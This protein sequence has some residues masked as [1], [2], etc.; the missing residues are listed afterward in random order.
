M[1]LIN[2]YPT[3][4][5]EFMSMRPII[6]NSERKQRQKLFKKTDNEKEKL[7]QSKKD[8]VFNNIKL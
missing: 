4:N 7:K 6:S 2:N 5:A 3:Y 8:F 1:K